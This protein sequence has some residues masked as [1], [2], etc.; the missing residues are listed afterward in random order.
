MAMASPH[1]PLQRSTPKRVAPVAEAVL[2]VPHCMDGNSFVKQFKSID[3]RAEPPSAGSAHH[4]AA[5]D[6]TPWKARTEVQLCWVKTGLQLSF[7]AKD[8][9]QLTLKSNYTKCNSRIFN[10]EVMEFFIAPGAA[11]PTRYTEIDVSPNN[12]R[13]VAEVSKPLDSWVN[14][15]TRYFPETCTAETPCDCRE[16][17]SGVISTTR[18]FLGDRNRKHSWASQL[19][20]PWAAIGAGAADLPTR[21]ASATFRGNFYRIAIVNASRL[22]GEKGEC[23]ATPNGACAYGAWVPTG[24]T[25][26][27]VADR[28]GTLLLRPRY[29]GYRCP[30]L[31]YR[32]R[33]AGAERPR[34]FDDCACYYGHEKEDGKCLKKK[35]EQAEA[36]AKEADE[37]KKKRPTEPSYTCPAKAYVAKTAR[38]PLRSFA[39][40]AC[41]YGTE[42]DAGAGGGAGGCA[43]VPVAET[44]RCPA[45]SFVRLGAAY[46]LSGFGDCECYSGYMKEAAA[47]GEAESVLAEEADTTPAPTP[48]PTLADGVERRLQVQESSTSAVDRCVPMPKP[49]RPEN[50]DDGN[51]KAVAL[52]CPANAYIA[53]DKWP[54]TKISDDCACRWGFV[55]DETKGECVAVQVMEARKRAAARRDG[56]KMVSY[57]IRIV[58]KAGITCEQA[59]RYM[60]V[61]MEALKKALGVEE[62]YIKTT[63]CEASTETVSSRRLT[64]GDAA[65]GLSADIGALTTV[66]DG[67]N[68][69]PDTTNSEVVQTTLTDLG[70]ELAQQPEVATTTT[71]PDGT[72]TTGSDD[73]GGNNG[74][75]RDDASLSSGAVI[76]LAVCGCIGLIALAV[77]AVVTT[78]RNNQQGVDQKE[79]EVVETS[80]TVDQL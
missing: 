45:K 44:Y 35:K 31:S 74:A 51:S 36:D 64:T 67:T 37:K 20:V 63:S 14:S 5:E 62:L 54:L 60:K 12:V 6:T 53:T 78:R 38:Y 52:S 11:H 16:E 47:A 66:A 77:A 25:S 21:N 46:P 55:M 3:G 40:C 26:F 48:A 72:T 17:K 50:D 58:F 68:P 7:Q 32:T 15:T 76:A 57:R 73:T 29:A 1:L 69:M 18:K 71:N 13:F 80:D 19:T 8:D 9:K 59:L 24:S 27:H 30:P 28:F 2:R 42:R 4:A 61:I 10:Q 65:G 79:Q 34:S 23:P 75:G 43:D 41:S 22:D 49:T 70:T 56:R 33:A 39:D